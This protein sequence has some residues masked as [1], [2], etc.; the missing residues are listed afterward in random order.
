MALTPQSS[1]NTLDAAV[2]AFHAGDLTGARRRAEAVL[3]REPRN[4]DARFLLARLWLEGGELLRG[5]R[6]LELLLRQMPD[7]AAGQMVMGQVLARLNEP[8]RARP[9]LERAIEL[10]REIPEAW[11][12]LAILDEQQETLAKAID[13]LRNAQ[14]ILPQHAGILGNLATALAKDGQTA[15]ARQT[16]ERVLKLDAKSA[17][18]HF[19]LGRLL[20]DSGDYDL[21]L[22]HYQR[23]IALNPNLADAHHNLGNLLLDMDRADEAMRAFHTATRLRF[24]PGAQGQRNPTYFRR[25]TPVK[26]R[27][28]IE[29]LGYLQ[30]QG[31]I[32]AEADQIIADHQRALDGLPAAKAGEVTVELPAAAQARLA[33]NYNRLLLWDADT[34]IDGPAVNPDL[35]WR[36]IEADYHQRG[37]GITWFDGLLTPTALAALRRFCLTSTIWSEFRFAN[38]YVGSFIEGGFCCPL[39]LQIAKELAQS[40]PA[41]FDGHPVAKMWA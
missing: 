32:G 34:A 2:I 41:I 23:A 16:F 5:R 20:R 33:P 22:Q 12:Q 31:L 30:S 8:V 37:P 11:L 29:Q 25:T 36:R 38:G 19:N 10:D 6:E 9:H 35:D 18:T 15:A 28:D 3:K 7:H 13:R 26:L 1:P 40:L 17:I 27:H 39:L 4:A 24:A 14:A 21:A